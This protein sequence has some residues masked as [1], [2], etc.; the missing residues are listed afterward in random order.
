MAISAIFMSMITIIGA[1]VIGLTVFTKGVTAGGGFLVG[2][3]I[4]T[5]RLFILIPIPIR[6]RRLLLNLRLS[7][8]LVCRLLLLI[9]APIRQGII[10]M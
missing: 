6:R 4:I 3:G 10:L 8:L 2:F 9:I 7:R 1:K 5:P